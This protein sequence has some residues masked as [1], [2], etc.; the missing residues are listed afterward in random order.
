MFVSDR[1]FKS[2]VLGAGAALVAKSTLLP[3][4]ARHLRL[5]TLAA[6]VT[7]VAV[8]NTFFYRSVQPSQRRVPEPLYRINYP[9]NVA[10][11]YQL[12]NCCDRSC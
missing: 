4:S 12:L 8:S 1:A 10:N 7:F 9:V 11:P 2:Y 3:T 5:D 6:V